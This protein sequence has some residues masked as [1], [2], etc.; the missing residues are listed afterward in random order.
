M[1]QK[2]NIFIFIL[3]LVIGCK[4]DT[5]DFSD[6]PQLSLAESP[7]QVQLHGK[8]SIV[9][10]TLNYKDGNGD[11]G[12]NVD[13]TF[14][15]Y[16]Y[17]TRYFHNLIVKVYRVDDGLISSVLIPF[18]PPA[19]PDTVN[20][21][22]RILNL[23]PTGKSKAISGQIKLFIKALPYPGVAPDSMFYTFQL[24]DR[25]LNESEI[26]KTDVMRFVF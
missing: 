12:L 23:T 19:I 11:I 5:S 10:I 26:V 4:Q 21:N 24:I 13:D 20:Y 17:P 8:D 22:E 2:Y 16:N 18:T 6:I 7:Q 1:A 9:N 14:P 25:A 15:P 3:T